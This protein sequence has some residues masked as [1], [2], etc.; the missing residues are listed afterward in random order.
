MLLSLHAVL[1]LGPDIAPD[2][3]AAPAERD[4]CGLSTGLMSLTIQ[5][6]RDSYVIYQDSNIR[7]KSYHRTA[8]NSA[9]S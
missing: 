1:E 2:P 6:D 8:E 3:A 7:S 5:A 9:I 4:D